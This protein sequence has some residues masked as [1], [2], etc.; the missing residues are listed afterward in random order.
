MEN[1]KPSI[2]TKGLLDIVSSFIV[3]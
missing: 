3:R 1:K 2:H